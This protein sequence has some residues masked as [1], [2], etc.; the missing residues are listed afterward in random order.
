MHAGS[1]LTPTG[2]CC[3]GLVVAMW[4]RTD[5]GTS[6]RGPGVEVRV[7]TEVVVP[8]AHW[9]PRFP[10]LAGSSEGRQSGHAEAEVTQPHMPCRQVAG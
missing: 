7:E 4:S 5:L 1:A 3:T 9:C 2:I 6:V 10:S 8:V